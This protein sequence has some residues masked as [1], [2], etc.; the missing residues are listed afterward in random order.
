[1]KHGLHIMLQRLVKSTVKTAPRPNLMFE[2]PWRC[3]SLSSAARK[4]RP[5]KSD[6]IRSR[7]AGSVDITSSNC[8]C[9]G[10]SF[11]ITT[12]PL[13]SRICALISPGCW[14]INV[15]SDTSPEITALR[16]SFTQV[17]QR[18]SVSR[19]KPSGGALRSYDLSSG[20]GAQF[21]RI[22]SPSGRRWLTDWNA[23]QA[24]SERL[25]MSRDPLTPDNLLFSDSPRRN[26]SLNN[27]FWS[28]PQSK[29]PELQGIINRICR[30][31]K[32]GLS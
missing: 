11:R 26:W 1:M 23:F 22:D 3:T 31:H 18:L 9:F 6:S 2:V 28:P 21:G 32:T 14:C 27:G 15:S 16:T 24:T 25:E 29:R 19:G 5:K 17:G 30:I 4:S 12:W 13:S 8:P 10:Q 20:P 7:N